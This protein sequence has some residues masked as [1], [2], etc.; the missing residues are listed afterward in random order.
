M[1]EFATFEIRVSCGADMAKLASADREQAIVGAAGVT[2]EAVALL[3]G[4]LADQVLG[5]PNVGDDDWLEY[6]RA[7]SNWSEQQR[8]HHQRDWYLV[9]MQIERRL[10]LD[11]TGNVINARRHGASWQ[12]IC[13]ASGIRWQPALDRWAEFDR[14]AAR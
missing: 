11:H 4:R 12:A 10:G 2:R 7:Q 14:L 9:K 6:A 3:I 1:T 13:F 5:R 8:D